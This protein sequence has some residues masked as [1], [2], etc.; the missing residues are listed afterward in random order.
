MIIDD[1]EEKIRIHKPKMLYT[2]PTFQNPTGKTL[3][4]ERRKRIAQLASEQNVIVLEDDQVI[5]QDGFKQL[6]NEDHKYSVNY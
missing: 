5:Q 2:I 3:T 1:L 6:A 4:E